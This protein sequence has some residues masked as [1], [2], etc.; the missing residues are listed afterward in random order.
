MA[1]YRF[2][3]TGIPVLE[4]LER[5]AN[6]YQHLQAWG[7]QATALK[8]TATVVWIQTVTDIPT[9]KFNN[10]NAE[11]GFACTRTTNEPTTAP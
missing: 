7:V 2:N 10:L 8:M 3:P 9:A 1:Y 11:V 4:R 6:L 5:L